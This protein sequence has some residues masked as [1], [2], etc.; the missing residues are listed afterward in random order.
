VPLTAEPSLQPQK[1]LF[2]LNVKENVECVSRRQKNM[3]ISPEH[4]RPWVATIAEGWQVPWGLVSSVTHCL[5]KGT[6]P[7]NY[8]LELCKYHRLLTRLYFFRSGLLLK[9][10]LTTMEV[11]VSGQ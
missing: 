11:T 5:T 9:L 7:E 2:F 10:E 3:Q 1:V 4:A 8:V 6:D